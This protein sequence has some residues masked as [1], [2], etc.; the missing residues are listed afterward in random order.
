MKKIASIIS[1]LVLVFIFS[2]CASRSPE[3]LKKVSIGMTKQQVYATG[4]EPTRMSAKGNTEYLV[5]SHCS[6]FRAVLTQRCNGI[7]EDYYIRLV[8]NR[9]DSY[10]KVGDFDSTQDPSQTVNLNIRNR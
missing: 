7:E 5:Y 8:N 9:V 3:V 10:G 2:G 1:L 4:I 6:G